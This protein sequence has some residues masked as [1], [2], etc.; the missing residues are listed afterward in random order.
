MPGFVSWVLGIVCWVLGLVFWV[1]GFVFWVLGLVFWVL[2]F[3]FWVCVQHRRAAWALSKLLCTW[4]SSSANPKNGPKRQILHIFWYFLGPG[5]V[6]EASP[7]L[8]IEFPVKNV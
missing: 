1:L 5:L 3:V 6:P 4:P 8:G 2:G 7:G